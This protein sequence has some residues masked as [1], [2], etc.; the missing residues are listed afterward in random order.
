MRSAVQAYDMNLCETVCQH[1]PAE[2]RP[3]LRSLLLPSRVAPQPEAELVPALLQELR[4]DAGNVNQSETP[5]LR[6]KIREWT[7]SEPNRFL[8]RTFDSSA[9]TSTFMSA[10]AAWARRDRSIV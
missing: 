3:R 2:V 4:A 1:I 8:N 9:Y 10:E 7:S 5:A 6:E